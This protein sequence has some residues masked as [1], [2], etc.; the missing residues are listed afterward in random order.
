MANMDVA[1]QGPVKL[2]RKYKL[3]Y[4]LKDGTFQELDPSAA[5]EGIID[6]ATALLASA[7]TPTNSVS[8]IVIVIGNNANSNG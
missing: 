8:K 6:S 3:K 5:Q 4:Q 2:I 7:L 1:P